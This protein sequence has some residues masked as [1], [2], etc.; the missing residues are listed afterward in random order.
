MKRPEIFE[1]MTI[2]IIQ[3]GMG[4]GI[5]MGGLAGAVAREGGMGVIS[6]ANIGFLEPDFWKDPEGSGV[7][8]LKKEIG[9]ARE[10]AGGRGMIAVNIM[11]ATSQF[12]EMVHTAVRAGADAVISGAGLP[13]SL[14]AY[15]EGGNALLAPI[16]S[17][18]KA[19]K[20]IMAKWKRDYGKEP[21]FFVME[22]S[23]A[24]GHLGFKKND[25]LEGRVKSAASLTRETAEAC[26]DIPVFSA[27]GVFDRNDIEEMKKAGAA[28]V[29][30]ATRF[31]AT[32]ECD[33]SDGFKKVILEAGP[34][35]AVIIDSPVGMPGRAVK[36]PLIER[37]L[38]G[39][40][41]NPLSCIRCIT[42]CVP[43]EGPYCINR[44]LIA[45]WH[46]DRE[47]GLFFCGANVG[48]INRMTTV[49]ELLRELTG[50]DRK[51]K[52]K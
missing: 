8:A 24:G 22:G 18:G 9:K 32:E 2:P 47:N 52:E 34:E 31:I 30:I 7:R 11:T 17:G 49:K 5:T 35:D 45:A 12:A 50:E 3:G 33:A 1:R 46:G 27:G 23:L 39:E 13:L 19:A 29:Q 25:L 38:R 40:K 36:T 37:V 20:L 51:G 6:S 28:G 42:K 41:E 44:A 43:G 26:G 10:I 21:D 48:R 15:A 16:V 14:P 4:V